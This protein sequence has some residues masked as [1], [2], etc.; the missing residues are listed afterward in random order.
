M[1]VLDVAF[2]ILN[3]GSVQEEKKKSIS[4]FVD[5]VIQK[6]NLIRDG[7][8]CKHRNRFGCYKSNKQGDKA[9]GRNYL[10]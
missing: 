7:C 1:V 8:R 2:P 4:H 6:Q 9:L 5:S 10:R 3:Y